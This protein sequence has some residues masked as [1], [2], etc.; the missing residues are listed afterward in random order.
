MVFCILLSVSIGPPFGPDSSTR[1][2]LSRYTSGLSAF[3]ATIKHAVLPDFASRITDGK[4]DFGPWEQ[5]FYGE[6]DGR[7]A[8]RVLVKVIGE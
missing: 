1:W 2:W 5:V 6:F 8:K 3:N 4:F 7:R